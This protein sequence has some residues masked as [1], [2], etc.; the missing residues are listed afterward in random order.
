MCPLFFE[1]R[2]F[3]L[4]LGYVPSLNCGFVFDEG[5]VLLAYGFHNTQAPVPNTFIIT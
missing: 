3:E 1:Q 2:H 5:A 4:G